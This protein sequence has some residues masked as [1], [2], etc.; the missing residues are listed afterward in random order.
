M[1]PLARVG[2]LV[3]ASAAAWFNGDT[4]PLHWPGCREGMPAYRSTAGSGGS[5]TPC[6]TKSLAQRKR[7]NLAQQDGR[8]PAGMPGLMGELNLLQIITQE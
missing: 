1:P 7:R 8:A 2:H 5:G 6:P 3:K 4:P